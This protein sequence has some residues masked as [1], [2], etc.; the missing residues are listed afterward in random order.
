MP[1][2]RQVLVVLAAKGFGKDKPARKVDE[3]EGPSRRP[4]GKRIAQNTA[5]T[6]GGLVGGDSQRN[7]LEQQLLVP[8]QPTQDDDEFAKRLAELRQKGRE[9]A[10]EKSTQAVPGGGSDAVLGATPA[11]FDARRED[12]YASPP[13]LSQ[14]LMSI[15]SDI[16]D[17]KLRDAKIGPSQVGLAAGAIVFIAVFIVVAAGDYAPSKRSGAKPAQAPPDA[18]QEKVLKGRVAVY[19]EQLKVNPND[20]NALADLASAYAKLYEFDK[21]A[22][23]LERLTKIVPDSRDTWRLLGEASLLN[24]Q[25]KRAVPAFERAVQLLAAETGGAPPDIQI[26]TGLTDAYIGASDYTKA[27]DQLQRVRQQLKAS[28]P[29]A[30]DAASASAPAA[31][32]AGP[33][34][35]PAAT[36]TAD[37]AATTSA[38]AAASPAPAPA[39]S[40]P[41]GASPAAR[42]Q[43]PPDPVSVELLIGKAYNAWRGHDND[44]LATYD[45]VIKSFPEDF[46]GYLAKGVFLKDKG[47]KADAERMF[48]QA[49]FYAPA[50]RQSL[51]RSLS[52]SGPALMLPDN[53]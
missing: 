47:R 44:A 6:V 52:E 46:R 15:G 31:A 38:G 9:I 27:I 25:P 10:A 14:T 20:P 53:N 34:E 17:P 29:A 33:G 36:A 45:G 49:R 28:P 19:E 4:K 26:L 43:R 51:V 39:S 12:V 21:A 2:R 42:P 41:S 5:M 11:A 32:A 40:P 23:L 35:Q 7:A 37:G 18:I 1:G 8:D 13:P 30:S 48:L 50:N 16:A 3:D 24:Q 22:S